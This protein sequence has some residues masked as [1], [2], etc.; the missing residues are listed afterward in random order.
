MTDAVTNQLESHEADAW[1]EF[2]RH[3][4]PQTQRDCGIEHFQ[5]G[6]AR[7]VMAAQVD[8]LAFN[9]VIGLG[10]EQPA[11][12]AMLDEIVH[13]YRDAGVGRFFV[14][15]SPQALPTEVPSWLD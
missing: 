8:V 10:L 7:A 11:T 3:A 1:S 2:Y 14:Q 12:E 6:G 15:L 13:R 5:I 4:S 9:R